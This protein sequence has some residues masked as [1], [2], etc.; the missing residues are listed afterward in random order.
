MSSYK[1]GSYVRQN[2]MKK[3]KVAITVTRL[4]DA[5]SHESDNNINTQEAE[6]EQWFERLFSE[7]GSSDTSDWPNVESSS[8]EEE[9]LESI[10]EKTPTPDLP[11]RGRFS[12]LV[13]IGKCKLRIKKH[14]PNQIVEPI[15]FARSQRKFPTEFLGWFTWKRYKNLTD[16][17]LAYIQ[18]KLSQHLKGSP[19]MNNFVDNFCAYEHER[20]CRPHVLKFMQSL[21]Q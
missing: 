5:I 8:I 3:K 11:V 16:Y 20:F 4:T 9:S 13:S 15:I 1:S 6:Q 21:R 2:S 18:T 14:D 7:D 17:R 12:R 19:Q 10:D